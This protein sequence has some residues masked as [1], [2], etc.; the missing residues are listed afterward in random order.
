[1]VHTCHELSLEDKLWAS[2]SPPT[3]W[4]PV[5]Q[6]SWLHLVVLTHNYGTISLGQEEVS[7]NFSFLKPSLT[8]L[9]FSN[10]ASR[11]SLASTHTIIQSRLFILVATFC[12]F[13]LPAFVSGVHLPG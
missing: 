2:V 5:I 7:K 13:F 12:V 3:M 9:H 11:I 6:L 8:I 4:V 1:M 10:G